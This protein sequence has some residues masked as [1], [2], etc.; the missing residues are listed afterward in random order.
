MLKLYHGCPGE[1]EHSRNWLICSLFATALMLFIS[2]GLLWAII[3]DKACAEVEG[4]FPNPDDIIAVDK[5]PEAVKSVIPAYPETAI[6]EG[7]SGEVLLQVLID[8]EGEVRFVRVLKPS[9]V[10]AGFEE[11]AVKAA[12]QFR[13]KPAIVDDEPVAIWVKCPVK[14]KLN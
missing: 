4:T 5:M 7:L 13:Y 6:K 8:S 9:G 10:D 2:S 3:P 12:Y 14:F 1:D 11:A